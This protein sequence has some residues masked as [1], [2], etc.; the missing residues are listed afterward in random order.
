M[1]MSSTAVPA[2]M[3]TGQVAVARVNSVLVTN[4]VKQRDIT[5]Q[6]AFRLH[7]SKDRPLGFDLHDAAC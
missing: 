7:I 5:F 4:K 6:L 3:G 2:H 1:Q